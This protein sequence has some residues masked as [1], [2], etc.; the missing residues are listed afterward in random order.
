LTKNFADLSATDKQKWLGQCNPT[1]GCTGCVANPQCEDHN[2][3]TFDTCENGQC[4]NKIIDNIFCD[5]KVDGQPITFQS[6]PSLR[7]RFILA[8]YSF[9]SIPGS[10]Q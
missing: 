1:I 6:I 7:D 2:G 4:Q 5:P 9:S 10:S 8:G 3:C